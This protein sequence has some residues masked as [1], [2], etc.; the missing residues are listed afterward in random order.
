MDSTNFKQTF[1]QRM[2]N[3]HF[4]TLKFCINFLQDM[5]L[6]DKQNFKQLKFSSLQTLVALTSSSV[7][8][9]NFPTKNKKTKTVASPP[10]FFYF[11]RHLLIHLNNTFTT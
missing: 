1:C 2:A 5:K 3:P 7:Q 4:S 11:G 8:N 9:L 6:F 10:P